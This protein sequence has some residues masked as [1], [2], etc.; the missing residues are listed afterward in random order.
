M[1]T[2]LL[3]A[4]VDVAAHRGNAPTRLGRALAAT[5]QPAG[6]ATDVPDAAGPPRLVEPLV[7]QMVV[8]LRARIRELPS[9]TAGTRGFV[10][11]GE[12]VTGVRAG[13]WLQVLQPPFGF[14][15]VAHDD[16]EAILALAHEAPG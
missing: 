11:I 13:R 15:L 2:R 4:F 3:A 7:A 16:G 10:E 12:T 6:A 5:L 8:R 9:L 14:V 1:V